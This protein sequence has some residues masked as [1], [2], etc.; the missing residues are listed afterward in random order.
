MNKIKQHIP[1]WVDGYEPEITEF[2]TLDELLAIPWVKK[3]TTIPEFYRFSASSDQSADRF[4]VPEMTHLMAE[5]KQGREWW[6]VGLMKHNVPEL[7]EWKPV[8]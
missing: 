4:L 6:V 3:W 7:P 5:L 1:N 8:R 2:N